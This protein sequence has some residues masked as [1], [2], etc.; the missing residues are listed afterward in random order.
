[1]LSGRAEARDRLGDEAAHFRKYEIPT[2]NVLRK[3]DGTLDWR[4]Y[5]LSARRPRE[6]C[7]CALSRLV[8]E[9]K[10]GL[11]IPCLRRPDAAH[12]RDDHRFMKYVLLHGYSLGGQRETTCYLITSEERQIR[13]NEKH[14]KEFLL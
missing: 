6:V 3:K 13:R 7:V 4:V 14:K 9:Y 10:D 5:L 11:R 8:F 1:M 12:A 2:R